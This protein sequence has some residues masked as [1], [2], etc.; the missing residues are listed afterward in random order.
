VN[1]HI[2]PIRRHG[3]RRSLRNPLLPHWPSLPHCFWYRHSNY[4]SHPHALPRCRQNRHLRP[5]EGYRLWQ[6][7]RVHFLRAPRI[8]GHHR[9]PRSGVPGLQHR[10]HAAQEPDHSGPQ[11]A[12]VYLAI[13]R[14]G[15][16]RGIGWWA[17]REFSRQG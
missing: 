5:L 8:R 4:H 2:P 14:G 9:H 1:P 17:A 7:S 11:A 3:R 13:G 15:R 6:A 16:L 12:G 10:G